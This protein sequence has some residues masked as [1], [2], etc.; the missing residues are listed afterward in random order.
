MIDEATGLPKL[1]EGQ[2]WEVERIGE[3]ADNLVIVKLLHK[4]EYWQSTSSLHPPEDDDPKEALIA[5]CKTEHGEHFIRLDDVQTNVRNGPMVGWWRPKPAWVSKSVSGRARLWSWSYTYYSEPFA[6]T[7]E[8]I[9]TE[10]EKIMR[11]SEEVK[12]SEKFC[13]IYPPNKLEAP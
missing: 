11:R 4:I 8:R 7:A 3:P 9:R 12:E 2:A 5:M 6:P 13:G 10:A 1:P